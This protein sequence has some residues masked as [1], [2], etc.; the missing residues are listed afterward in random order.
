MDDHEGDGWVTV[1]ATGGFYQPVA[2][3]VPSFVGLIS[4][5]DLEGIADPADIPAVGET[6]FVSLPG[7]AA[8][9]RIDRV[10]A[11]D[12]LIHL[13]GVMPTPLPEPID[14]WEDDL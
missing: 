5:V 2:V 7:G 3:I 6:S 9:L 12:A 10:N 1:H 13:S 4:L 11:F 14:E 8:R